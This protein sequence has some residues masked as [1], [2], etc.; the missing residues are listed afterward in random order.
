MCF[1]ATASFT[2]AAIL[3]PAGHYAIRCARDIDPKWT[4]L[5]AFPVIFGI[6]QVLEGLLWIGLNS[7]HKTLAALAARGFLFFSHLVWPVLA[8]L[9]IYWL[10]RSSPRSRT[11]LGLTIVGGVF[12][13]SIF[14]PVLLFDGWVAT[15][16]VQYSI[17]YKIKLIYDGILSHGVLRAGYAF[18][19]LSPFLLASDLKVRL[20]GAVIAASMIAAAMFYEMTFISV[21]CFFAAILSL[22]VVFMLEHVRRNAHLQ[23]EKASP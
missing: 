23:D 5:A 16:E 7:D 18:I 6:Q 19:I 14:L 20:F 2:A 10:E 17:Q 12:G 21:W 15:K 3:I 4:L 9:S 13:L 8:P 22:Y 11:L 1:S